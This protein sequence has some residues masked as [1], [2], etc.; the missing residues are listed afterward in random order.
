MSHRD[1]DDPHN[2]RRSASPRRAASPRS[3]AA[4]ALA[5]L[6]AAQGGES[7]AA[8]STAP[9]LPGTP[10]QW[11]H[12]PRYLQDNRF[13]P[14]SQ[15]P[16]YRNRETANRK[17][18]NDN[19]AKDFQKLPKNAACEEWITTL[20]EDFGPHFNRKEYRPWCTKVLEIHSI[21][22]R[23]ARIYRLDREAWIRAHNPRLA[24]AGRAF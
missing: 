9:G 2:W 22:H 8:P 18:F 15:F 14:H 24:A 5:M 4:A 11:E 19:L 10:K 1:R 13:G 7:Y 23:T 21:G 16:P 3:A 12:D 17:N 6:N 20:R